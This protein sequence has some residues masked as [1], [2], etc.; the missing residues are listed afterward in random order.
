MSAD[1]QKAFAEQLRTAG[2][3][4]EYVE[5]DGCLHRCATEGR[6]HHRDGAYKAFSDVPASL[7]WKNWRTGDEGSWCGKGHGHA[8]PRK[9]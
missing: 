7:W 1:I 8:S 3:I 5:T 2:L 6:P 4:V 9:N